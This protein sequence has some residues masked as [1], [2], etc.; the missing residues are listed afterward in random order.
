MWKKL[1]A[2]NTRV[3]FAVAY[4]PQGISTERISGEVERLTCNFCRLQHE[5]NPVD[6]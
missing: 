4:H 3:L 1:V 5:F 2:L 6:S